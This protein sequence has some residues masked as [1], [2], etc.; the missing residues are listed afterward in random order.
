MAHQNSHRVFGDNSNTSCPFCTQQFESE[1]PKFYSHVGHHMEDIRL[2]SLPPSHRQSDEL[3]H[4]YQG[5]DNSSDTETLGV[6]AHV[7]PGALA[8]VQEEV[9]HDTAPGELEQYLKAHDQT[10]KAHFLGKWFTNAGMASDPDWLT[11]GGSS[12]SNNE[13]AGFS[14]P[15]E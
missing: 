14:K 2:F 9:T 8:S 10:E 4:A 11:V 3:D 5:L 1:D 6:I 12:A 15:S 13:F 7:G